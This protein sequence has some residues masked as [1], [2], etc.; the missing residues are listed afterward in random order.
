MR[1][2][3]IL[4]CVFFFN[5]LIPTT[6]RPHIY[7]L[8]CLLSRIE[9]KR[10]IIPALLEALQNHKSS[11]INLNY[12]YGLLFTWENLKL[13]HIVCHKKGAHNLLCDAKK[14]FRKA[15]DTNKAKQNVKGKKRRLVWTFLLWSFKRFHF[16]WGYKSITLIRLAVICQTKELNAYFEI[17]KNIY[18]VLCVGTVM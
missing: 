16:L 18:Y 9:K 5:F 7:Y 11:D 15:S 12:F 17:M 13:V 8:F 6:L 4:C 2:L 1:K 14:I 3:I 10:T